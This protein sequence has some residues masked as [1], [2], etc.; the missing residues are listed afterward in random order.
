MKFFGLGSYP[1]FLYFFPVSRGFFCR[2]FS[3]PPSVSCRYVSKTPLIFLDVFCDV[4]FTILFLG[5]LSLRT[6][7][8]PLIRH[9]I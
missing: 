7:L 4:F 9:V 2:G 8:G 1:G 3:W 6:E 5:N